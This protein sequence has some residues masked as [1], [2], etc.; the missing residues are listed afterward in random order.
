MHRLLSNPIQPRD[1]DSVLRC[2]GPHERSDLGA[3]REGRCG[4][5][6]HNRFEQPAEPLRRQR[7]RRY[8]PR[9]ADVRDGFCVL[10]R[11]GLHVHDDDRRV[12]Q[13]H[14]RQPDPEHVHGQQPQ[15]NV[16]RRRTRCGSGVAPIDRKF[17]PACTTSV[18]VT[19]RAARSCAAA[20]AYRSSTRLTNGTS[21]RSPGSC[22]QKLVRNYILELLGKDG[23][24]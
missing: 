15:H 14:R 4:P 23:N 12:L 2:N 22:S 18:K 19:T 17:R 5:L 9:R 21:P 6:L 1:L 20:T 24:K 7:D 3:V 16:R 8:L 11:C 10:D 13:R